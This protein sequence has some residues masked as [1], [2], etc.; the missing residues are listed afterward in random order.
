VHWSYG[1]ILRRALAAG[2][3]V[4]ILVGAY[5]YAVV[6]P[7]IDAAI[8]LEEANGASRAADDGSQRHDEPL[9]SRGEQVAGGVAATFITTIVVAA[10]FGTVYSALRHRVPAQS[11]LSRALWLAAVGFLVVALI[12]A[13]KYPAS[14][15]GVGD[16]ATVGDRTVLYLICL[17]ASVL[18]TI[19][20][21]WLSGI[22][23]ARVTD[24][25]RLPAVVI[26][27]IV[28]YGLLLV[29]LPAAPGSAEAAVPAELVWEFRVRSL[30]GLALLWLGLGLGLGW[31][32]DHDANRI[33]NLRAVPVAR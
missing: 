16:P 10:V 19:A 6:E 14:P 20:L 27:G 17:V 29:L 28:A 21:T 13:L 11:D 33:S 30:G 31:L 5:V 7:T 12:P 4:G 32:L 26:A 22:L 1:S 2:A 25:N 23:R 24:R 18:I 8:A 9:F 15:P 3:V